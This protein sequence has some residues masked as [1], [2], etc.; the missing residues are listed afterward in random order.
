VDKADAAPHILT[1]EAPPPA[2]VDWVH[3]SDGVRLRLA[4]WAGTRAT[5]W[6]LPG[7][8]EFIE[9]YEAI[10]GRLVA[11]GY[12]VVVVDWRTHGLSDRTVP[13]VAIGHVMDF[14]EFQRDLAAFMAAPAVQ[15]L[16]APRL[17]LAHSMGGCIGLRALVDGA[18]FDRA[19]F[20]APMW[21]LPLSRLSRATVRVMLWATDSFGLHRRFLPGHKATPY[22]SVTPFA[23]NELTGDREQYHRFRDLVAAEPR[24]GLGG[25]SLGWLGAAQAEMAALRAA[26]PPRLPALCLVGT[27]ET[28]VS[29]DAIRAGAARL[30]A[31]RLVEYE[32]AK[33]EVL[34]ETPAIRD[35]VWAEI[36]DFLA[37]AGDSRA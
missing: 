13:D 8:T 16:P 22:I 2:A 17:M 10:A 36:E 5:V 11:Q 25:V 4:V 14:D 19:V 26:P 24:L 6:I 3:A 29:I 27:D 35:R 37:A 9:K 21:G 1:G 30:P 23:Q 34:I 20:S 32:D 15:D 7:R 28:I 33:H 31:G 18:A 12:A